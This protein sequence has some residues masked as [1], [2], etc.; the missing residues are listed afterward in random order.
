MLKKIVVFVFVIGYHS[1][2]S[3]SQCIAT[4]RSHLASLRT[5]IKNKDKE[6]AWLCL[7]VTKSA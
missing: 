4:V 6:L 2:H 5:K 7:R 1:F 3:H